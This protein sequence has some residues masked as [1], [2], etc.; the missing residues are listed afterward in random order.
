MYLKEIQL[1]MARA[2]GPGSY[3]PTSEREGR[4]YPE[5]Y[6]RWTEHRNMEE[7]LRHVATKRID[8]ASLGSYTFALENAERAY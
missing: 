3:D 4:D 8:V 1:F 7:F 6:V 2:Y 5:A